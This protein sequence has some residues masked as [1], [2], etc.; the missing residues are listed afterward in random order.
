M[1]IKFLGI[2]IIIIS[3]NLSGCFTSS[4]KKPVIVVDKSQYQYTVEKTADNEILTQYEP[5]PVAAQ[6][7]KTFSK[8]HQGITFDT[9]PDQAIRAV[10]DGIVVYSDFMQNHGQMLVIKH[11][12]GFYST[13][14]QGANLKVS[15]GDNVK[16]GQIIALTSAVDFYFTM[17]KFQTPIDPLKYLR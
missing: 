13:Y 1:R 8:Q 17:K 15:Q 7:L 5:L 3:L 14:T 6:P 4:I 9:K 2:L 16:K 11:R 10:Q 12:L